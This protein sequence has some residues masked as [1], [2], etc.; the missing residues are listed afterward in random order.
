MGKR[1]KFDIRVRCF[2]SSC[3][4]LDFEG[5]AR[6]SIYHP[7]PHGILMRC[8]KKVSL[9]CFVVLLHCGNCYEE[10]VVDAEAHKRIGV[11]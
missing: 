8:R 6:V 1:F 5:N 2:W 4:L 7:N 11:F 9:F 10:I 3:S